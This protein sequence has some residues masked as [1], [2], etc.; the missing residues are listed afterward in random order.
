MSGLWVENLVLFLGVLTILLALVWSLRRLLRP[1][2]WWQD[3]DWSSEE[4][5]ANLA[6]SQHR[7]EAYDAA[8][9]IAYRSGDLSAALQ[10][11]T[12]KVGDAFRDFGDGM[13]EAVAPI[14]AFGEKVAAL[15]PYSRR[16]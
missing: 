1:K 2:R 10:Y 14:R 5:I 9:E 8:L 13:L 3:A 12:R 16:V 7:E 11:Q 4:R 6:W 15:D